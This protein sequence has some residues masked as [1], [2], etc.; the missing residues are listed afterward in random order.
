MNKVAIFSVPRSGS[1]WLG[2]IFNSHPEVVF[3]FQPN[4]AYSFNYQLTEDSSEK[5]I[6]EFYQGLINTNDAFVKGEIT[7]SSKKGVSFNKEEAR[8]IVFKETH[9]I[10]VITNLIRKS[11]TKVIGLIRSPFAV[12]NSWIKIPKEFDFS[13]SVKDEW[14]KAE[15]KNKGKK[16]YYFG[17]EKWK[18]A[19]F[20]FLE[21]KK[22]RPRQFYLVNYDSL[23]TDKDTVVKDVFHFCNLEMRSQT[24]EFLNKSSKKNEEDAYSVFK[25]K[26]KDDDWRKELPQSIIE[27][28]EAD[29]DFKRLNKIF[30]WIS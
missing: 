24:L 18:E 6:Y 2:Q 17:Y 4:F 11:D 29:D 30:K 9:F 1:S 3:R 13:W 22:N 20:L 10:N 28:I 27:E 23:L 5:D 7:I 12:I 19:A 25:K 8:A 26:M 16:A 14:R 15:L 21:L